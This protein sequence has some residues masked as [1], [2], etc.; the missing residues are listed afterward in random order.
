MNNT[1]Y[2]NYVLNLTCIIEIQVI[3]CVLIYIIIIMKN[4]L[5]NIVDNLYDKYFLTLGN[6]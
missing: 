2:N 5:L 4:K 1:K 3:L 6:C